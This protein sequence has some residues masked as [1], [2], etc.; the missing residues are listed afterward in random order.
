MKGDT[1]EQKNNIF[2]ELFIFPVFFQ[3]DNFAKLCAKIIILLQSQLLQALKHKSS[4]SFVMFSLSE[5]GLTSTYLHISL[6]KKCDMHI[7]AD[8]NPALAVI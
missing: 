5:Y 2:L 4:K 7:S 1:G 6:P 8:F 3:A